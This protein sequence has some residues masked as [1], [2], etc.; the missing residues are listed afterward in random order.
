MLNLLRPVNLRFIILIIRKIET[1]Y[2]ILNAGNGELEVIGNVISGYQNMWNNL[3][4]YV[5][6]EMDVKPT[7]IGTLQS[8]KWEVGKQKVKGEQYL[9]SGCVGSCSD[10]FECS[11][12]CFLY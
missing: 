10:V 2:L 1:P 6:M 3:R 7:K 5:Y 4:V 8:D 11:L 9:C 12:W